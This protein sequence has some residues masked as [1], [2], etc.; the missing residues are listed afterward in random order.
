MEVGARRSRSHFDEKNETGP[1]RIVDT[2][3]FHEIPSGL[4]GIEHDHGASKNLKV[5]NVTY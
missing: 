4:Q 1:T 3:L 2:A 5:Y